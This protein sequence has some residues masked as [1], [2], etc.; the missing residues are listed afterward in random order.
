MHR[1]CHEAL[2]HNPLD[3]TPQKTIQKR[4]AGICLHS[5]HVSETRG[6]VKASLTDSH[7]MVTT[8]IAASQRRVAAT[9]NKSVGS[10]NYAHEVHRSSRSPQDVVE[11]GKKDEHTVRGFEERQFGEWLTRAHRGQRQRRVG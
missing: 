3:P 11:G 9:V 2:P 4:R 1:F 10:F 6:D 5:N 8:N 7:L